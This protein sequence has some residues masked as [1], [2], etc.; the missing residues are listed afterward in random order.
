MFFVFVCLCLQATGLHAFSATTS[1]GSV[2]VAENAG[3]DMTCSYSA[4]FG[5]SPRVEWK[6]QNIK[7]VTAF[8][9]YDGQITSSYVSRFSQ[10]PGGLRILKATRADTG[11]YTCEVSGNGGYAEIDVK[12]TVLVPPSVPVS[13][14]PTSV[15]T[16][17][18]VLL[19]CFDKEGSPPCTYTWFKDNTPLPTDPTKF[20]N[21]Q[22]MTY[23]M[24]AQNGNLEFPSV[25]KAATG[26]YFCE[27]NNG[28]GPA[29]RGQ[30]VFMEVRDL[31]TGGIVAGIIVALLAIALLCF[32]L[33]YANKKGYLPKMPES[34]PKSTSVYTQ[35]RAEYRDE[36]EFRQKSSFVV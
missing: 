15:T 35:P 31:N 30:T 22:N 7:G 36:G 12:L 23:K 19:T 6:S 29:Q 18:N 33:W 16:G 26:N 3:A 4:D 13:H 14:I 20:P 24:N 28:Q 27:A 9:Y 8:V 11:T 25:S 17:R 1:A 21:F 5:S 2:M 10:F 32:G 34:K